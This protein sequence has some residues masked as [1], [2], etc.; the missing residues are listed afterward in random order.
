MSIRKLLV[1]D[2][3]P[4]VLAL[5]LTGISVTVNHLITRYTSTPIIEYSMDSDES[6][7]GFIYTYMISNLTTDKLFTD[8]RLQ[9]TIP[10]SDLVNDSKIDSAIFYYI[11]PYRTFSNVEITKTRESVLFPIT[12][13]Q[14]KS[15]LFLKVKFNRMAHPELVYTDDHKV[16]E[17]IL[18]TQSSL[19]TW[20]IRNEIEINIGLI[21]LLLF[22]LLV[23]L[24]SLCRL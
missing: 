19:L 13:L 12:Y 8:I 21:I 1:T 16:Q 4:F 11:S 15:R 2:K 23:Y 10:K 14:P 22:S 9:V 7:G 6:N 18:F 17:A 5:I 24:I 20:L 3:I